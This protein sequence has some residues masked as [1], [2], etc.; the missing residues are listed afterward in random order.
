MD[1]DKIIDKLRKIKAHAESAAKIGSEAEA[2]AFAAM[3]QQ[4]LLKHKI[5]MT[6]L[7]LEAEEADE[8]VGTKPI[9]WED[10]KVRKNRIAWIEQLAAIVAKAYFCQIIVHART[11]VITLVGRKGDV[12]VA[13]FMI[14]T[15]T[16]LAEKLAKKE[17]GKLYRQD[18]YAAHGFK[19]SFLKSFVRRI[20]ERLELE[21][22]GAESKSSTALVR[23][24]R[25]DA[26]V[27]A[28]LDEARRAGHTKR[29]SIVRGSRQDVNAEGWRRGRAVA[30][31]L[32]LKANALNGGAGA[33]SS[34]SSQR[35]LGGS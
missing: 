1:V 2:E 5:E 29:A 19:D 3:L 10:V 25:A 13:E 28:F 26:A 34:S 8:P 15:L 31:G 27:Q 20:H 21:R 35:A 16:R 30:D 23:I 18:R 33:S 14:V 12:A 11:S 32:S 4:L 17:F 7:E 6:D 9:N 24:N 22:R